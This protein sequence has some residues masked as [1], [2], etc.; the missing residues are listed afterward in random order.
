MATSS[1]VI[2]CGVSVAASRVA[3]AGSAAPR[4]ASDWIPRLDIPLVDLKSGRATPVFAR[5]VTEMNR[6]MGGVQGKTIPQLVQELESARAEL[7]A[8]IS[9]ARQ[10]TQ[11]AR[12]V[13]ATSAVTAEVSQSSGLAGAGSIPPPSEPPV[14]NPKLQDEPL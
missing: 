8:A 12:G 9:Y 14:Y 13:A 3:W 2:R 4:E 1:G 11:Y 7:V 5:Y 6:R 10:V